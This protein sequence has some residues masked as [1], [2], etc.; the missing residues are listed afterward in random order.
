MKNKIYFDKIS[1]QVLLIGY[2]NALRRPYM[3]FI[4]VPTMHPLV[5]KFVTSIFLSDSFL[6]NNEE[7]NCSVQ[8]LAFLFTIAGLV[9]ELFS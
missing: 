4:L 2:F 8:E 9:L 5:E 1:L 7:V 3:Y 6:L